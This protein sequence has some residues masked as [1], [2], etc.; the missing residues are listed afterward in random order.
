METFGDA[1]LSSRTELVQEA[2]LEYVHL[3]E[4]ALPWECLIIIEVVGAQFHSRPWRAVATM[5]NSVNTATALVANGVPSAE[6]MLQRSPAHST[7]P[8]SSAVHLPQPIV[9]KTMPAKIISLVLQRSVE[10]V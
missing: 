3:E 1:L 5:V 6:L 9:F 7:Q 10:F 2:F 8:L 4:V